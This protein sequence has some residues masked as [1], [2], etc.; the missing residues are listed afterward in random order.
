[1]EELYNKMF[2][3][4]FLEIME[5]SLLDNS[6]KLKTITDKD[7]I[8]EYQ[9]Q[10]DTIKKVCVEIKKVIDYRN[11]IIKEKSELFENFVT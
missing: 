7:E 3:S 5:Q 4:D 1:M 8:K 2:W 6:E 9:H 11:K 10:L